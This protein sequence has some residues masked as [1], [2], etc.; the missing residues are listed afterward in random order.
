MLRQES[1]NLLIIHL[2][3]MQSHSLKGRFFLKRIY[4]VV[5]INLPEMTTVKCNGTNISYD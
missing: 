5:N 4:I 2:Q 3:R 1:G